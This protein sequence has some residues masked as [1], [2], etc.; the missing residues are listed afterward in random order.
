MPQSAIDAVEVDHVSPADKLGQLIVSLVQQKKKAMLRGEIP[1]D[2][3]HERDIE[4]HGTDEPWEAAAPRVNGAPVFSC[5]DCGGPL[6]LVSDNVTRFRCAVGHAHSADTLLSAQSQEVERALWVA[7]RT[8]RERAAM[9][10]K[11][12]ADARARGQNKAAAMW[13]D[14][15]GEFEQHAKVIHELLMSTASASVRVPAET[16]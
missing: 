7:F 9:L 10:R 15:A 14:R 8:N 13:D 12:A 3:R 6:S 5:P 11:M 2:I 4:V 1:A 16:A